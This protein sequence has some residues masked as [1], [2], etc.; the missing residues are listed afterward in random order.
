MLK[1]RSPASVTCS[2]ASKRKSVCL[3]YDQG[4]EM[5][6][7]Q[8]LTEATG[9]KVTFADPHSPLQRGINKNAFGLLRQYLPKGSDLSGFTQKGLDAIAWKLNTRPRKTLGF[10]CP[11]ELF[12]PDAFDFRQHHA[13]LFGL[14]C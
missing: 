14:G 11:A 4:R 5:A 12:T 1:R 10:K 8:R 7:H 13:A 9:V 3:T 6:A 2:I